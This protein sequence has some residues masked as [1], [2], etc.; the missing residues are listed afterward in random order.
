MAGPITSGALSAVTFCSWHP[1]I[2]MEGVDRAT[3][4]NGAISVVGGTAL[5][6]PSS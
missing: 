6:Y 1:V 5:W 2:T 3:R 4:A